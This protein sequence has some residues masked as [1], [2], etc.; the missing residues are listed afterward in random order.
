MTAPQLASKLVVWSKHNIKYPEA[1]VHA[2][3][4]L[5][6]SLGEGLVKDYFT[7]H[8]PIEITTVCQIPSCTNKTASK[9]C[10]DCTNIVAGSAASRLLN[11][12]GEFLCGRNV[13]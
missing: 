4:Y 9:Y 12:L 8:Y 13:A 6:H 10:T 7:L 1:L 3:N 11:I 5:Q 2:Q